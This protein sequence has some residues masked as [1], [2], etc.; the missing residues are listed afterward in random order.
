[1]KITDVEAFGLVA[2]LKEPWKIAKVVISEMN[3]TAVK[4]STEFPAI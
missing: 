3:A 2:P 1:M 4:I